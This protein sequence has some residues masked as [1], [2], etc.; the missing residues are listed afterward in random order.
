M[1]P[2]ALELLWCFLH[3][4]CNNAQLLWQR[5]IHV[6]PACCTFPAAERVPKDLLQ[7]YQRLLA[8]Q[9]A[10]RLNPKQL[11][12]AGVLRNRLAEATS[13]LEN[14]SIKETME[15][16]DNRKTD[17]TYIQYVQMKTLC[18]CPRHLSHNHAAVIHIPLRPVNAR[19]L[20]FMCH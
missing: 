20:F 15:K 17:S 5:E 1:Q 10:R 2:R 12:E 16:V 4:Q 14:L 7:F 13:F 6:L 9:P 18:L 8:S 3:H 11:L 19:T